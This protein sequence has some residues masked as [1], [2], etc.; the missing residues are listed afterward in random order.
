MDISQ[1][2]NLLHVKAR[3]QQ[4]SYLESIGSE[5]MPDKQVPHPWD[6]SVEVLSDALNLTLPH[7]IGKPYSLEG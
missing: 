2:L 3:Q 6:Y 4:Q 7:A 5:S 1:A